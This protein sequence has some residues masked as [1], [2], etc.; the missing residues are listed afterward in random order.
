MSRSTHRH[1]RP[2]TSLPRPR[3]SFSRARTSFARPRMSFPRARTSFARPRMSFPRPLCAPH[4]PFPLSASF[5]RSAPPPRPVMTAAIGK[6][7]PAPL[8]KGGVGE[9]P[10]T[11]SARGKPPLPPYKGGVG[12]EAEEFLLTN[13]S[14]LVYDILNAEKVALQKIG[15]YDFTSV[16]GRIMATAE[17]KR[18]A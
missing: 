5:P 1:S 13:R 15:G 17:A 10:Q 2:H 16:H 11:A 9:S 7:P 6:T 14:G 8:F 18:R 4:A 3:M 12:G